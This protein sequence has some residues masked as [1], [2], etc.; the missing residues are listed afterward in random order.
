[1][2][3]EDVE[4]PDHRDELIEVGH[5]DRVARPLLVGS[6]RAC[7]VRLPVLVSARLAQR[8]RRHLAFDMWMGSAARP[9]ATSGERGDDRQ[10]T[11]KEGRT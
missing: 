9:P 6:A 11:E 3:G 1:L 2:R 5:D 7:G 4:A 8:G 10:N